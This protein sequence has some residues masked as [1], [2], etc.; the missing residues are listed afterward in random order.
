MQFRKQIKILS[1]MSLFLF[2]NSCA[3]LDKYSFDAAVIDLSIFEKEGMFV[4][5]GDISRNYKS[6]SI[7][8]VDCYQGYV[9]KE[10][11]KIKKSKSSNSGYDDLY[12]SKSTSFD[13]IKDFNFKGC[14]INDL[15]EE[16]IY[17][18]KG[19]DANSII[20]LEIRNISKSSVDGRSSVPGIQVIGLAINI[21]D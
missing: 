19:S 15:F 21:E 10:D 3:I 6:A 16:I 4:T 11:V 17:Q 12:G 5:T 8:I 13:K 7:V 20:K 9:P 1:K 14:E 18:A 2:F